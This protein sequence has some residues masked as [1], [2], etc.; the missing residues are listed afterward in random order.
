MGC[1]DEMNYEILL[2][3][4][5]FKECADFIKKNFKDMPRE[6]CSQDTWEGGRSEAEEEGVEDAETIM[7]T[8]MTCCVKPPAACVYKE[9]ESKICLIAVLFQ[10]IHPESYRFH[11]L[12]AHS[13]H[14]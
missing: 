7:P 6:F 1:I 3:N 5:S 10:V 14:T 4:S 11:L 12:I 8:I 9:N 2:P 13:Q